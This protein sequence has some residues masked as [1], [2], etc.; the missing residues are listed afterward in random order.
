[1]SAGAPNLPTETDPPPKAIDGGKLPETSLEGQLDAE[2]AELVP[3]PPTR[4]QVV[5]RVLEVGSFHSG[6]LPPS[7]EL[8]EY[9]RIHSGLANRVVVM[10]EKEQSH[11]HAR[12]DRVIRAETGYARQHCGLGQLY[13]CCSLGRLSGSWR[14]AKSGAEARF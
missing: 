12:E 3:E 13:S 1:M 10:A 4:T 2:L 14:R 6:P 5:Q 11:R 9:E 7:R 8:A